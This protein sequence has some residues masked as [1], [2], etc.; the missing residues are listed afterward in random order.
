LTTS[1][2]FLQLQLNPLDV[3]PGGTVLYRRFAYSACL[4]GRH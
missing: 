2:Y 1:G 4:Y 3:T